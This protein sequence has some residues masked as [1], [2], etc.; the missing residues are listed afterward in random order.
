MYYIIAYEMKKGRKFQIST[1]KEKNVLIKESV[2]FLLF[3]AHTKVLGWDFV[4]IVKLK[5]FIL[6]CVLSAYNLSGGEWYR[7]W[8]VCQRER[9]TDREHN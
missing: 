5:W 8:S 4:I 7:K 9:Q 6:R 2:L 3:E 1:W